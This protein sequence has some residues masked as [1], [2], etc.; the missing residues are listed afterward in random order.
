MSVRDQWEKKI[1]NVI[2]WWIVGG[3]YFITSI[4]VMLF[5]SFEKVSKFFVDNYFAIFTIFAIILILFF[6]FLVK[7]FEE[8]TKK[9]LYICIKIN[10]EAYI[11]IG[12]SIYINANNSSEPLGF[13]VISL[14]LLGTIKIVDAIFSL[15]DYLM[16]EQNYN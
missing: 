6:L 7:Y 4:A 3:F 13:I 1:H 2:G 14:L 15:K 16:F 12:S 5:L 11:F 10:I 9:Q 8:R